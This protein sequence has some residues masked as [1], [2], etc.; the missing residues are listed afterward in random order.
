M[1][2]AFVTDSLAAN[3]KVP[4]R[5]IEHIYSAPRKATPGGL[6]LQPAG[7]GEVVDEGFGIAALGVDLAA[8]ADLHDL[9]DRDHDLVEQLRQ[10][11]LGRLIQVTQSG[12]RDGR[13]R[14]R[15]GHDGGYIGAV[16]RHQDDPADA[17]GTQ[18][19]ATEPLTQGEAWQAMQPGELATFVDGSRVR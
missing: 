14:D 13:R 12:R 19:V 17:C 18:I 10:P 1:S 8:A 15:E 16:T 11:A 3:R 7:L 4:P 2:P 9:L 6:G 5:V